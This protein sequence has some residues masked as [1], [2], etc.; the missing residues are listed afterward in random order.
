MK[1]TVIF[2]LDGL[3]IDSEPVAFQLYCDLTAEYDRH[4]SLEEYIHRYSGKT[5]VDN[6]RTLID[7]YQ[8]PLTIEDGLAFEAVKE[9]EYI[10]K[11]IPLKQGA[12]ELLSYLQDRNYK[13]ILASSGT[14]ER[15]MEILTQNQAEN[16]FDQ[17]VFGTEVKRGKPHPDIFIKACEYAKEPPEN[18]LVLEDS[19]AGIQA[20]SA[21]G[22]DVICIPDMKMPAETFRKMTAA[23]LSSLKDVIVWLEREQS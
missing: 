10:A 8:L 6:M 14:R 9:K 5:A 4:I 16:A 20:A 15:A 18:C 19:E 3:L 22:I 23:E 13:I 2:D 21:A 7:A 11:G 17:M 1:N 12:R